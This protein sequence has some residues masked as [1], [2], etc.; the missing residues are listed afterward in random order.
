[1]NFGLYEWAKQFRQD[2]LTP[3]ARL[4]LRDLLTPRVVLGAPFREPQPQEPPAPQ[5]Q[6]RDLVNWEIRFNR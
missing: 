6:I 3:S 4:E 1:M 5:C 2:G